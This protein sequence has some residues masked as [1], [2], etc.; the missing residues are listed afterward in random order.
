[1]SEKKEYTEVVRSG[2][3]AQ[4]IVL[5]IAAFLLG[6]VTATVVDDLFIEKSFGPPSV[7]AAQDS[8]ESR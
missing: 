8:N 1:M 4:Q 7:V 6:A 3:S 2:F 5:I